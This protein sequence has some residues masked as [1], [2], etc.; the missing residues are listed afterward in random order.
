MDAKE[1]YEEEPQQAL[2]LRAMADALH[3]VGSVEELQKR[4]SLAAFD[5]EIDATARRALIERSLAEHF[6][7]QLAADRQKRIADDLAFQS[8]RRPSPEKQVSSDT[9][10]W[11]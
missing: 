4:D 1:A 9:S 11:S 8:A 7:V 5:G 6:L 2:C 10:H 3:G